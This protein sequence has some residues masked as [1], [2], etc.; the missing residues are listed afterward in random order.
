MIVVEE[1]FKVG[2]QFKIVTSR[3]GVKDARKDNY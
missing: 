3:L 2:G 1:V